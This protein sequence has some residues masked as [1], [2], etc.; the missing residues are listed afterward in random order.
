MIYGKSP[1]ANDVV[2]VFCNGRKIK[3]VNIKKGRGYEKQ[4][5]I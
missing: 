3:V 4:Q 5:V 1:T 2:G